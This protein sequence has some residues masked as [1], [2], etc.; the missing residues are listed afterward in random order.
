LISENSLLLSTTR[1]RSD[2]SQSARLNASV[3]IRE[4]RNELKRKAWGTEIGLARF[5]KRMKNGQRDQIACHHILIARN[6]PVGLK[7]RKPK[8]NRATLVIGVSSY[9][10]RLKTGRILAVNQILLRY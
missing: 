10:A 2:S 8:K 7:K 5:S 1:R 6:G 4:D 3:D 9:L